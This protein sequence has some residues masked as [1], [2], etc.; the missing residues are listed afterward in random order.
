MLKF[1]GQD[2]ILGSGIHFSPNSIF[3]M[4]YMENCLYMGYLYWYSTIGMGGLVFKA[5]ASDVTDDVFDPG[6]LLL[7]IQFLLF[8]MVDVFLMREQNDVIS[9]KTLPC[10]DYTQTAH[11]SYSP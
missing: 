10:V 2:R 11:I 7:S 4:R 5:P 8:I 9:K 6:W 3:Y 1:G